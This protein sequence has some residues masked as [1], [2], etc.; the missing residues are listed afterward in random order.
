MWKNVPS[1]GSGIDCFISTDFCAV[2]NEALSSLTGV[3][4]VS[5]EGLAILIKYQVRFSTPVGPITYTECLT[6]AIVS[7]NQTMSQ[8]HPANLTLFM[9]AL[10]I[11]TFPR[12]NAS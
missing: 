4:G 8:Y 10:K 9:I 6:K 7:V 3:P 11:W 5:T 1:T 2:D 12:T